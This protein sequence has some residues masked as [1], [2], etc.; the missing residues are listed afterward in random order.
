[1]ALGWRWSRESG[2]KSKSPQTAFS[3]F[4]SSSEKKI[5]S[6]QKNTHLSFLRFHETPYTRKKKKT[7]VV[8]HTTWY[9]LGWSEIRVSWT[10]SRTATKSA[11]SEMAVKIELR[12]GGM[13]W[14]VVLFLW[15]LVMTPHSPFSFSRSLMGRIKWKKYIY[16]IEPWNHIALEKRKVAGWLLARWRWDGSDGY[17]FKVLFFILRFWRSG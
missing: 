16:R 4:I 15:C 7:R 9:R 12:E 17:Y 2:T 8:M 13:D 5:S 1:M 3:T 10:W 14:S 11:P 6:L